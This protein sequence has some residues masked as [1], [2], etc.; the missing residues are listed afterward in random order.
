VVL[1]GALNDLAQRAAAI[2]EQRD[3]LRLKA[4][5]ARFGA[6]TSSAGARGGRASGR[7][8][9][10]PEKKS[11]GASPV[12]DNVGSRLAAADDDKQEDEDSG[13]EADEESWR[14]LVQ[15]GDGGEGDD[16]VH[17]LRSFLQR[18]QNAL[19]RQ[20]ELHGSRGEDDDAPP[21]PPPPP[22]ATT[23]RRRTGSEASGVSGI[24]HIAGSIVSGFTSIFA[25]ATPAA[26]AAP[27]GSPPP[28]PAPPAM[29]PL[30]QVTL[31]SRSKAGMRP[32]HGTPE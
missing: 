7:N 6:R 8:E 14:Q 17:S 3:A 18:A 13:D 29:S 16:D 25:P 23:T 27:P 5:H 10:S 1:E 26:P 30:S 31:Q 24:Q 22:P 11:A 15:H 12:T 4:A 9:A 2:Q 20:Q 19:K 32:T 21:P 28:T